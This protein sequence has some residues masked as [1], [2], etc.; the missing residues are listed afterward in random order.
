MTSLCETLVVPMKTILILEDNDERIA[1]F[2]KAVAALGDGFD[3]KVWRDAPSMIAECEHVLPDSGFDFTRS[4][5]ESD[6]GCD[7]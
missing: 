2:Q 3:L 7:G 1:A 6:A 4:R 5:S